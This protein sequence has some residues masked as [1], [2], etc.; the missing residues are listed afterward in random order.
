M[1]KNLFEAISSELKNKKPLHESKSID[2]QLSINESSSKI[3]E[4]ILCES[5]DVKESLDLMKRMEMISE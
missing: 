5:P 1:T 2:A 3:N 4:T